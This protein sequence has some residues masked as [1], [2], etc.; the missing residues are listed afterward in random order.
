MTARE[1]AKECGIEIV[2]KL[3]KKVNENKEFDLL[4]GEMIIK[5]TVYWID[6][7]GNELSKENG[8]W[9]LV[10]PDGTVY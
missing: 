4:K 1:Y 10:T 6:E 9:C 3:T 2:G 7:V 5:K 8:K